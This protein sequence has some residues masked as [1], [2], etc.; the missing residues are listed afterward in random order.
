M[1]SD[2]IARLFVIYFQDMTVDGRR[3]FA[4]CG[5]VIGGNWEVIGDMDLCITMILLGAKLSG[6]QFYLD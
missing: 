4:V 3:L 2:K 1:S 6:S 5:F